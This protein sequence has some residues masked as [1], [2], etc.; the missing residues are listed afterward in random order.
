VP[1]VSA[2]RWT[3]AALLFDQPAAGTDKGGDEILAPDASDDGLLRRRANDGD[4]D[5][6]RPR[7]RIGDVA[8]RPME[9]GRVEL[10]DAERP[11]V[12][13]VV[14][15]RGRWHATLLGTDEGG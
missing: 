15:R 7:R 13:C 6:E 12:R 5:R 8:R 14:R 2:S 4:F 9:A 11:L 3:N 1:A 10:E